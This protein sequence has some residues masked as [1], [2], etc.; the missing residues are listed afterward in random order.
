LILA[1]FEISKNPE[2]AE[3]LYL[4]AMEVCGHEEQVTWEHVQQLE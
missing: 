2:V 1:L 4:E 3:K